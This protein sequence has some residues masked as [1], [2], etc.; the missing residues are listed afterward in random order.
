[1]IKREYTTTMSAIR[2]RMERGH[3]DSVKV[4]VAIK[5]ANSYG[6]DY[7][8]GEVNRWDQ[9]DDTS[10][11]IRVTE[12]EYDSGTVNLFIVTEGEIPSYH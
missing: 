6:Y 2:N 9:I 8:F 3:F 4:Q 1:M 10:G 11:T 5:N 7:I 12:K